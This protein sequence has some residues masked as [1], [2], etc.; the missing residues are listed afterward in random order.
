[1]EQMKRKMSAEAIEEFAE[2]LRG[3]LIDNELWMDCCIYF[4][5]KAFSTDDMSGHYSYNDRNDLIVID[6]IDPHD[7]FD[8]VGDILSM[9]FEG[10]LYE[11][12][13]GYTGRLGADACE[14]FTGIFY[15]HGLY[16]EF[17]DSWNLSA[18]EL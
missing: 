3:W 1:M 2:E 4:N 14:E 7:Y 11:V 8:Y 6:D 12:L 16:Y 13:N 5:G 18:Y 17:G 10:P 9:S 15:R